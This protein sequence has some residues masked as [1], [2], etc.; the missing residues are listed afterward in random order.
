MAGPAVPREAWQTGAGVGGASGVDALGPLGYV[1]VVQSGGAVVDGA[2]VHD[3]FEHKAHSVG[4]EAPVTSPVPSRV[5]H[6]SGL[7]HWGHSAWTPDLRASLRHQSLLPLAWN[8]R[9]SCLL[10]TDAA[11]G[12][13][14]HTSSRAVHEAWLSRSVSPQGSASGHSPHQVSHPTPLL[15]MWRWSVVGAHRC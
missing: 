8:L 14:W 3:S 13:S 15:W 7:V 11:S 10:P 2:L 1:T 12:L 5:L 6:T 4:R 9:L